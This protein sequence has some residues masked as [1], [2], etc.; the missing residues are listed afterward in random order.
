MRPVML[1]TMLMIAVL[2][3]VEGA[4]NSAAPQE[5]KPVAGAPAIGTAHSERDR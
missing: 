5:L 1:Y 4:G 2:N 3:A